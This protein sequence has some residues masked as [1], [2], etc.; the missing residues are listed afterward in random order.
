MPKDLPFQKSILFWMIYFLLF[1]AKSCSKCL[2]SKLLQNTNR[3]SKTKSN[4]WKRRFFG[5]PVP[6]HSTYQSKF[7]IVKSWHRRNKILP[8]DCHRNKFNL[9]LHL[10]LKESLVWNYF[11]HCC[12]MTHSI[13]DRWKEK[14]CHVLD[15]CR[16]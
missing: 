4:L 3:S 1:W 13:W 16:L 7:K 11:R 5:T 15:F 14:L 8:F 6:L 2:S 10:S 12:N 9:R